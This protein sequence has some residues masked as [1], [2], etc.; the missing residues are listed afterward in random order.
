MKKIMM[1]LSMVVV[2]N[3]CAREFKPT[4]R[5]RFFDDV[6]RYELAIVLFYEENKHVRHDRDL[7]EQIKWLKQ[8]FRDASKAEPYVAFLSLT[9]TKDELEDISRSYGVTQLPTAMLFRKG[10][11]R[12]TNDARWA[13]KIVIKRTG[14]LTYQEIINLVQ[15]Y[16]EHS[17]TTLLKSKNRLQNVELN[18]LVLMLYWG[19]YWGYGWGWGYPYYSRPYYYGGWPYYGYYW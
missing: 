12:T 18:K 6:S 1:M 9:F 5:H 15:D 17:S 7:S 2:I 13:Q 19:P 16:L 8:D 3:I 14:F 10:T 4:S 11:N